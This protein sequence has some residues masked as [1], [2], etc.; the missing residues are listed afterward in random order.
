[1]KKLFLNAL[2]VFR[3]SI[4]NVLGLIKSTINQALAVKEDLGDLSTA[5]L[6]QLIADNLLFE[7]MVKNRKHSA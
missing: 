3:L 4:D 7:P 6:N 5:T 2:Y 1:M